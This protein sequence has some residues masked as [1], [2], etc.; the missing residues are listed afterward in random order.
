MKNRTTILIAHDLNA[1]RHA[2]IIFVINNSELAEQG[3]HDD[4]LAK[5]GIYANLYKIQTAEGADE[6]SSQQVT[7]AESSSK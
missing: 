4:L 2:D 7:T 5:G 6:T 1:L 3:T